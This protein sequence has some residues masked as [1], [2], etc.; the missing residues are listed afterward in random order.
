MKMQEKLKYIVRPVRTNEKIV[1][2]AAVVFTNK[3]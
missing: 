3:L 1:F 2:T